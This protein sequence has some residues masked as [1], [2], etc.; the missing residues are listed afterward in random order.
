MLKYY[1]PDVFFACDK[2]FGYITLYA[3]LLTLSSISILQNI[4]ISNS[5]KI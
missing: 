1:E 3:T 5:A 2:N 4:N